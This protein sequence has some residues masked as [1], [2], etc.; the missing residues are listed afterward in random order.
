MPQLKKKSSVKSKRKVK[1]IPVVKISEKYYQKRLRNNIG[2][3]CEVSCPSGRIDLLTDVELIEIKH[4]SLWKA[5]V[6]QVLIYGLYYPNH[7][8]RIHLFG[9]ANFNYLLHVVNQCDKLGI[10]VSCCWPY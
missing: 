1:Q 7:R 9:N 4:Y 8:K 3:K 2:G 10:R 5:A 6:G